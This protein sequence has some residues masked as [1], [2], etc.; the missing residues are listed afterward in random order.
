MTEVGQRERN[1]QERVL[2]FFTEKLGYQYLGNWRHRDNSNIE[3]ELLKEY[4]KEQSTSETAI[5]NTIFELERVAS[6]QSRSLYDV[7]KE[8]Y[9]LLDTE[10]K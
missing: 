2:R 3:D 6:D 4:L 5:E 1:T 8:F 10:L 9:G 7:N